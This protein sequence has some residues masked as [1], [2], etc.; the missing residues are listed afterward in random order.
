MVCLQYVLGSWFFCPDLTGG[1]TPFGGEEKV[2][3]KEEKYIHYPLSQTHPC[4]SCSF[5]HCYAHPNASILIL[6][7]LFRYFHYF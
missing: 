2:E 7:V 1:L 5:L 6:L 4:L 3:Q